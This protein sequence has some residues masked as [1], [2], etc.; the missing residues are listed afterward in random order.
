[1][2][3]GAA[4]ADAPWGGVTDGVG[5]RADH[6]ESGSVSVWQ[7]DRVLSGTGAVGEVER[8]PATAGTYHETRELFV[9]LFVGRGGASDGAQPSG[10]AE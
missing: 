7:A 2:S 3:G 9:A 4:L 8:E 5:L 1:M 10:M 6:R